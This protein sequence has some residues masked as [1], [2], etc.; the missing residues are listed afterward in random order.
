[1]AQAITVSNEP[2]VP[3]S[4][5]LFWGEN[6]SIGSV[7]VGGQTFGTPSA[8]ETR[9][10]DFS[11]WVKDRLGDGTFFYD[12]IVAEWDQSILKPIVEVFRQKQRW[13]YAGNGAW[14]EVGIS[15]ESIDLDS[16]KTYIAILDGTPYQD[17]SVYLAGHSSLDMHLRAYA[18]GENP[19]GYGLYYGAFGDD[20]TLVINSSAYNPGFA[21]GYD[22][23]YSAT[24]VDPEVIPDSGTSLMFLGAG[25]SAL[26][27][28]SRRLARS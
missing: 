6:P 11:F 17:E 20:S 18:G 23:A 21:A 14:N 26:V 12:F 4:I 25:L 22:L 24:F 15:G 10:T 16:S 1:M 9:L 8:T 19:A 2:A 5:G 7:S 3:G 27:L 13:D 28:L